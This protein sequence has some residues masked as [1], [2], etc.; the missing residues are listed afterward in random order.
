MTFRGNIGRI[1]GK[2]DS[3]VKVQPCTRT[4][5]GKKFY[6]KECKF[7]HEHDIRNFMDYSWK[8]IG[9]KPGID[10]FNTRTVGSLD[11]IAS[12]LCGVDYRERDLRQYQLMHDL[13]IYCIIDNYIGK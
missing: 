12:D 6:D 11:S 3:K 10:L 7:T 8:H 9:K 13:L 5:C 1:F 2:H 4:S